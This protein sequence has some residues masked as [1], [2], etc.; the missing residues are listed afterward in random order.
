MMVCDS[1]V[2]TVD[3]LSEHATC[4]MCYVRLRLTTS[5]CC[6]YFLAL[7]PVQ[8]VNIVILSMFPR[9]LARIEYITNA[10]VKALGNQHKATLILERVLGVD[11]YETVSAYINLA[12]YCYTANQ[13]LP[14]LRLLYR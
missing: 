7:M 8:L 10:P 9:Q 12:L 11:H 6:C 2:G 5:V 14:A 13:S 1:I 3:G 4:I